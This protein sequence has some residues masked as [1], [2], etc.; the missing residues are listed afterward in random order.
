MVIHGPKELILA[1]FGAL[2]L[3]GDTAMHD[4]TKEWLIMEDGVQKTVG[5]PD[6][7]LAVAILGQDGT[8]WKWYEGCEDVVAHKRIYSH[9]EE[10]HDNFLNERPYNLLSGAFVR[11]GEDDDDIETSYWGYNPYD[12]LSVQQMIDCPYDNKRGADLRESLSRA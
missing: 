4:A 3:T 10:L 6:I 7:P 9:F 1:G 8:Y 12:L 11:I 5:E 2:N